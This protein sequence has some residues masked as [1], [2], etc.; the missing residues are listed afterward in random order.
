MPGFGMDQRGAGWM[1]TEEV[2]LEEAL[3]E[4][5]RI[6]S[7][8]RR[9]FDLERSLELYERGSRLVRLCNHPLR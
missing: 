8:R 9:K 4:L 7:L 6:V 3:E 5:E 2:V 1:S